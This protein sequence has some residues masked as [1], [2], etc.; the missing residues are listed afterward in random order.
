MDLSLTIEEEQLVSS[1]ASLLKQESPAERVR[2]AEPTGFDAALWQRLESLG[3]PVMAAGDRDTAPATLF[4]LVL[5]AEQ[6]GAALASAPVIEGMV[7]SRLLDRCGEPA[8]ELL[9][10]VQAG[11]SIATI[12]LRGGPAS[13]PRLVAAGAVADIVIGV[14]ND[15]LIAVFGEPPG[16]R[17]ENLGCLPL[18][19]RDLTSGHRTV[20]AKGSDAARAA[21]SSHRDWKTLSAAQLVGVSQMALDLAVDYT[22]AREVFGAPIATFQTISHRLADDATAVDG[23]RL[24]A[25]KAAWAADEGRVDAESLA[26]MAWCFAS[27]TALKVTQDSLHYHGGYGFTREYDVQLYFRRAKAYA[28]ILGDPRIEYQRLADTLFPRTISR[29]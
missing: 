7:A 24:L 4:Q 27:E 17:V 9:Q 16:R 6:A 8:S 18:A 14:D 19:Y 15:E 2:L 23:T 28:L 11:R 25:Y 13:D 3:V 26:S 29:R 20:L 21:A 10:R 5:V 22:K 12:S 1:V